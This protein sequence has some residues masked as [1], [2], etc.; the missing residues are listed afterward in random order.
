MVISLFLSLPQAS[1]Q[2][3]SHIMHTIM[4]NIFRIYSLDHRFLLYVNA[5]VRNIILKHVTLAHTPLVSLFVRSRVPLVAMHCI[6]IQPTIESH[7]YIQRIWSCS[8][9][10][11]TNQT[12]SKLC[13]IVYCSTISYI[14]MRN[15]LGKPQFL[16]LIW[17]TRGVSKNKTIYGWIH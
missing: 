11:C 5:V 3:C 12:S 6:D 16:C 7:C 4:Y 14:I 2:T 17:L 10:N 1:L 13:N 15:S 9:T 8:D